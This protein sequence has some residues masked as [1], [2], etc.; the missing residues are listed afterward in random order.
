MTKSKLTL[1]LDPAV[2]QAARRLAAARNT[3]VSA[4]FSC[5]IKSLQT[6]DREPSID[7]GPLTRQA[8]GIVSLPERRSDCDLLTEALLDKQGSN[9]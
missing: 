6:Y 9:E 7:L 1:S 5:L 3:S 4:L 8:S 2:V